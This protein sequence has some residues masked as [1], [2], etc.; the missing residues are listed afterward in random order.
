MY[1]ADGSEKKEV[2][3]RKDERKKYTASPS[4]FF[5]IPHHFELSC[6]L[7]TLLINNRKIQNLITRAS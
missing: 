5:F 6:V 7:Y 4:Y 3:Q 2:K 1:E